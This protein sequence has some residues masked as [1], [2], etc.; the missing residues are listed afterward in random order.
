ML[1]VFSNTYIV[2]AAAGECSLNQWRSEHEQSECHSTV[3]GEVSP[4]NDGETGS[5]S[6]NSR[7]PV[8]SQRGA[9]LCDE[10]GNRRTAVGIAD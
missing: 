1:V 7:H 3:H 4:A 9:S 2:L 10:C 8:F 6:G 5:S